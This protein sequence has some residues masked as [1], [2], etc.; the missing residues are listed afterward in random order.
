MK[1]V[2]ILLP[3]NSKVDE[4]TVKHDEVK[5][6]GTGY[7]VM[8]VEEPVPMSMIESAKPPTADMSIY[9]S[10]DLFPG[11]LFDKVGIYS[12]RGYQI[13]VL[14]LY[15]V[16]YLPSSGELFYYSDM[17]VTIETSEEEHVNDMYHGSP[18]DRIEV[19][20]K[21]DNPETVDTYPLASSGVL[22][23]YD[24]LILTTEELKNGF[25]SLKQVHDARG[26]ST[27]I[28][29]LRDIKINP[30]S[31]TA[32]DVRDFIRDEY[33]NS[34]IQYVLLG[35]DDNVVPAK[36]L[37]VSGYDED[38]QNRLYETEM[39]SDLYFACLDGPYNSDGDELWGET[40]DGANGEDVDLIAEVYVGRACV[41]DSN[42]VSNFVQKTIS[43]L[44]TDYNDAY[45]RKSLMAGEY[46]GDFGVATWGGNYLDLLIDV[47]TEDGYT[48]QGI[49]SDRYEIDKL[50]DREWIDG[51]GWPASE[52]IDRLNAGVHILNHDGHSNYVYNMKMTIWDMDVFTNDK[53]FFTYSI[54]CMCGGFDQPDD[55]D[56]FAEYITAKIPQGAFAAIMNARYGFFWAYSTDGD[57]TRFK[58]EFWD[59][60]FEENIPVISKANQDSKEDNLHLLGRSC[61][62]WTYYQ[63]NYFGDPSIA[64]KISQ[65]PNK[66]SKPTGETSIEAGETYQYLSS[67]T[68]PE[69]SQVFYK[70][71]WG[72]G[73]FSEWLGPYGSGEEVEASHSWS[74]RGSYAV[75]VKAKDSEG[76][77][78]EW[79]DPLSV[80][81][82]RYKVFN[83]QL[84]VGLLERFPILYRLVKIF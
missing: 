15:P 52:I 57:G 72:D 66:P 58:R 6:L 44:N 8:P 77:E 11:D 21:V 71:G 9:G 70:W 33:Q 20:K 78:G 41:G 22:A 60:V 80:S 49:P 53:Y 36:M 55:D 5:S 38:Q 43:Y 35:G 75:K 2:Y 3:Y 31:V 62:R 10:D 34:G 67:T 64:F 17:K 30:N 59:A 4:I 39:P 27:Q 28:K 12:F 45:L 73:T 37:Y 84:I 82:P 63:L 79:S 32:E 29:T 83:K 65:P 13:L 51:E 76:I 18:E 42:E 1:G 23:Q 16:Q 81:L 25:N 61:I 50:Y 74:E 69:G 7:N 24:L 14:T 19:M 68:D 46:L 56:C 48:T 40:N 54:G 26:V 47:C